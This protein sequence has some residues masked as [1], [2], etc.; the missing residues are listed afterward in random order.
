MSIDNK[1]SLAYL[2]SDGWV[3]DK[4]KQENI[5]EIVKVYLKQPFINSHW[6]VMVL[7]REIC[8]DDGAIELLHQ[9]YGEEP[10]GDLDWD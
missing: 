3:V 5:K 9:K 7:G 2:T 4:P 10:P 8:T 1:H 6:K